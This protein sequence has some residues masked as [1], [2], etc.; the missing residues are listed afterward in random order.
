MIVQEIQIYDEEWLRFLQLSCL[1]KQRIP[2]R[3]KPFLKADMS[4][5]AGP[6]QRRFCDP[7]YKQMQLKV[8]LAALK[9]TDSTTIA[10]SKYHSLIQ[11]WHTTHSHWM[12][13]VLKRRQHAMY[14]A[15][16]QLTL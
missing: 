11:L 15:T 8:K 3:T 6:T 14:Q 9:L 1:E 16:H 5:T 12:E 7:K 13:P 10:P 2:E 4:Q